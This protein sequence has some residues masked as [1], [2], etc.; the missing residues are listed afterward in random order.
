MFRNSKGAARLNIS[1]IKDQASH[2]RV[3][4]SPTPSQQRFSN[5][6][7][8]FRCPLCSGQPYPKG[9]ASA[10][11]DVA[12]GAQAWPVAVGTAPNQG[13]HCE[14]D[15]HFKKCQYSY[16][17]SQKEVP[18]VELKGTLVGSH[19]FYSSLMEHNR[20]SVTSRHYLL[21]FV[22]R[23][24]YLGEEMRHWWRNMAKEMGVKSFSGFR[25]VL[26]PA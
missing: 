13:N 12:A 20:P 9:Y 11:T 15:K 4:R 8:W 7:V 16:I 10:G 21:F 5:F 22:K 19:L 24:E 2:Y 1:G 6:P 14:L 26:E 25:K 18:V 3:R 23:T 17:F